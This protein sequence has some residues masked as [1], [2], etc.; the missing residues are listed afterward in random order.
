[1][2]GQSIDIF[3]KTPSTSGGSWPTR[4]NLPAPGHDPGRPRVRRAARQRDRRQ[5]GQLPRPDADLGDRDRE[6]RAEGP[7][8]RDG[9]RHRRRQPVACMAMGQAGTDR[10]VVT[11]A[12]DA[13]RESFGWTYG[14]YWEVDPDE[15][16]LRFAHDS[17][18]V[19]EEFRRVTTEARFREGEGLDGQAW[20]ARD[21][22]FVP[23]LGEMKSCPR[24]GGPAGGAEVGRL[25][26]DPRWTARSSAPW[27]S[28]PSTKLS[29]SEQPA[30]DAAERRPAGL[31]AL[32]RASTSR[33]RSS[34]RRRTWRRKV[35]QL[36]KVAQA[37]ARG[38]PDGRGRRS[39][40][41]D[42]MGRLG[43][44][45]AKMI[46]DLKNVIGQV[47]E[48]ANQFAEGLAGRRRERQLPE[49]VVAEPGGDGR[50]DVGLGRAA[51]ARRSSRST[52]TP[53]PPR[54]LAE[55]TSHLAKQGGE[56]VD[57]AIEAMVLI[58]QVE[59]AGQRH[60]PGDQRDRQ[61]DEPAGPERRDRGRPGRRARPGL[62][63]RRRRGPQARRAV[64]G[65]RQGDH[66]AD[67]GVDPPRRRRR[68]ALG[69]GRRSRWRRS[70]RGSRR[71]PPASPR[72]PGPPRSSPS[73][74]PRSARRS[75]T[76]PRITETNASSSEE[77]S[78][79]AEELGAQAASLK[80][81][82]S[83]FKV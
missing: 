45:L 21:L 11:S 55:R 53:A 65:R 29:S 71:P 34:R 32:E 33:R 39:A 82:I 20:Q 6:A 36:M 73:R 56:S 19:G 28:S 69:E 64:E 8:G 80:G 7:R 77:L 10:E 18:S 22:V 70:S 61:P 59:R 48:S 41:D 4:K 40:G 12:L 52:R 74:P 38:R 30:G 62:R 79:S 5:D 47:I 17:G 25:L 51:S 75:R 13:V 9:R 42:D 63:R 60:H 16:A 58:K 81:V 23:D 44:A 66:R 15:Q 1:M 24:P 83:G 49:R 46:G 14:S 35:N 2:I 67:Q 43:E 76:S 72:S 54:E 50:G 26:P 37:A 3:H 78:A 31:D 27:T 68:P 57:Q